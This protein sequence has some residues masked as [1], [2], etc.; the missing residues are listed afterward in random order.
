M[1][2]S[3]ASRLPDEKRRLGNALKLT[4][5]FDRISCSDLC[6]VVRGNPTQKRFQ[7]L[8]RLYHLEF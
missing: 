4:S 2:S 5:K 6:P 7:S 1:Q 3:T 8:R